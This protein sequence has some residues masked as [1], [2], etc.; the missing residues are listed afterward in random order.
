[1]SRTGA[2]T[3]HS[4]YR[5]AADERQ[6]ESKCA[7]DAFFGRFRRVTILLAFWAAAAFYSIRGFRDDI[8]FASVDPHGPRRSPARRL[9]RRCDGAGPGVRQ[10]QLHQVRIPHPDARRQD[11]SSRPSMCPRIRS[12]SYPILLTRTPY[13]VKPYGVDQYKPDLGPSPLFGKEGYIFVYQD[14]RGRWMSE[15]EFVNMR[16]HNPAQERP[17]RH[18]REHRHLRHHRLAGQARAEPQRQGRHVGHLVSRLLHGGRHDRRPSRAQGGLAAG[19]GHRLVHR[20][21]LAPQR[22]LVPAARVQLHG[23]FGQPRPEPTKKFELHV[24]SRH[25]GRL[26]LLP[27]VWG[28]WPTPT[29]RYFKDD[30]AFWNE[31]DA[32]RHLRRLLEG[33]Q[34]SAAP[35]EHQAGRMTVGGWFDAENLFGALETYQERRDNQP[36]TGNILVM[37]PWIHGGWSSGDG[38]NAGRR[39]ASTPRRASSTANRSSCRSSSIT[40]RARA[41]FKHPEA[42][43]FETGTNQWRKHD[44][45]PPKDAQAASLCTST[46]SGKLACEAAGRRRRTSGLRRICQRPGQAGAVSSTR[47]PSA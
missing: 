46:P 21:R 13:S 25:A 15:G 16:P 24:R 43:V 7:A 33:P 41:T 10:G 19:A 26:R 20:R 22:R 2:V 44:A 38:D 40:S 23:R 5:N 42:W 36:E 12:Q 14:V 1:M 47:S 37:G 31:I 18:R 28:R 27:A 29:T 32:A 34:P 11:S 39:L 45:W 6:G 9:L 8:T 35:E 3:V 4:Y 17:D 30:V